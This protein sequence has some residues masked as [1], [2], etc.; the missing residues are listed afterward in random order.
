MNF[1][2]S[3]KGQIRVELTSADVTKALEALIGKGVR[4][5]RVIFIDELTVQLVMDRSDYGIVHNTAEKRGE[6]LSIIRR[7]G[8]FWI[9]SSASKRPVLLVGLLCLLLMMLI[10]PSTILFVRVQGNDTVPTRQ[11]LAA[12]ESC[13]IRFGA[14]RR[15]IRSEQVKNELLQAIPQLRWAG[16]NTSG[17]V[18]TISVREG[19]TESNAGKD[20]SVSSLVA[21][22]DGVILSC[23]VT[24]GSAQCAPGQAVRQGQVLI[25]GYTDCG[26]LIQA[27]RAE[28]E[29][30]AQTRRSISVKSPV[31]RRI[32]GPEKEVR[33]QYSLILGKKRI[34]FANSSRICD[35]SCG[36][37]Y[38]EY[39]ITLPGGFRLPVAL[40]VQTHICRMTRKADQHPE[41]MEEPILSFARQYL[42]SLMVSGT[43]V[44][45]VV[46]FSVKDGAA[47]LEADF[48]CREMIAQRRQEGIGETNGENS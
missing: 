28:G 35:A 44:D 25:S 16:V 8:L 27:T 12:A 32:C 30:F 45:E 9:I 3:L 21:R 40:A 7:N 19:K 15:R 43:V 26:L 46:F 14:S 17:C 10:L 48:I 37:M 39:Y 29:I 20:D 4:I 2:Q 47:I 18:A 1:W 31:E 6:S 23:T 38:E 13:G 34:N 22:Q 11:I 24:A 42:I 33:R 36:R 5:H 41:T